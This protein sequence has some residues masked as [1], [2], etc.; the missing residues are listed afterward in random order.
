MKILLFANMFPPEIRSAA[1]LMWELSESLVERGH[2]VTVVTS[3]HGG[4][5]RGVEML[6]GV[7]VVR[8]PT[9]AVQESRAP[10]V[11]RG[12]GQLFN[13]AAYLPA[14]LSAGEVDVSL[15]YSPP[16]A[17]GMVGA[18]LHRLH[19]VPHLLNVQDL[20][21]QYAIDLGMLENPAL[22]R[23]L[24]WIERA[25]YRNVQL[26]TVHSRG[27]AEFLA[28]QGVPAGKV[29]VVP[30]WIDTRRLRPSRDT[31]Y[32]RSAGLEG[33][34]VALF[35]GHL[36]FAQ[37][38]DSVVEAGALLRERPGIALLIVGE[39]VEKRRLEEKARKLG[40]TNVRFMPAVSENDY[41]QVVASADVCLATLQASLRC[42][43]VP[44][45]LLGYMAAGKPIIASFPEGGDGPRLVR[46][47]GCGICVPPGDPAR[48]AQAI[49]DAA[50]RPAE[51]RARGEQGRRF[52]E[53]NHDR[54]RAMDAYESLFERLIGRGQK[55]RAA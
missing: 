12:L 18:L 38:L 7:R 43:V 51:S 17:L 14:A 11:L 6:S 22:I 32:R 34:F 33:K 47:A 9:L 53:V 41:P 20:V 50:E 27:N 24:R 48:L 2:Q 35:S 15:C 19:G 54:E 13:S 30:N 25:V 49:L 44:A 26:I 31:G 1:R 36:G 4:R 55:R 16:L 52:V 42:P 3:A 37:D 8:V 28:R 39:G 45:K 46:D 5:R 29:A 23:A 10:A 40:L 21:P